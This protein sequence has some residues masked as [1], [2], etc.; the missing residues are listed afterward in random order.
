MD[1]PKAMGHDD[2]AKQ[3]WAYGESL[4][5]WGKWGKDDEK[6]ALNFITARERVRAAELVRRGAVFSL[7]LPIVDGRGP[8]VGLAGRFNPVHRMTIT[9]DGHGP[10]FSL[11]ATAGVTDD[12]IEMGCQSTT[13]WDGLAH[14][15][16]QAQLYNGF[17]AESVDGAGASRNGIEKVH[18]DFVGRGVL[19]DIAR[20]KGVDAL[21]PGYAITTEDLEECANDEGV[22]VGEGDLVLVRTGALT[23]PA[24]ADDWSIFHASP[25]PGLHYTTATWFAERRVAAIAADNNGVEAPSPLAGIRSPFHMVAMRDMGIHLGE[26]WWLDDLAVDCAHNGGYEFLLVAQAM[27]I[28]GAV[29]SPVNPIA[30]K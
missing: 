23:A 7:A 14:V 24:A 9:A 4:R 30:I 26:F 11:G 22:A 15:Y 13:Q 27:P 20:A 1:E 16:Y 29:G 19:L 3:I 25:R 2:A 10:T 8:M 18:A 21:A 5:T 12:L 6:G 17:P 28:S